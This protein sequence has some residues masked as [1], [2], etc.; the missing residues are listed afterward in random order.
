MHQ[1]KIFSGLCNPDLAKK[2]AKHFGEELGNI[3]INRFLSQELHVKVAED[4]CGKD[5]YVIQSCC[6]SDD[7]LELLIMIDTCRNALA[8]RVTAVIPYLTYMR[9]HTQFQYG[10]PLTAKM[11]PRLLKAAGADHVMTMDL[12]CSSVVDQTHISMENI[13]AEPAMVQWIKQNILEWKDKGII[14]S[15]DDV[16]GERGHQE[17]CPCDPWYLLTL[18]RNTP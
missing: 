6:S 8:W 11:L 3:Q 10:D 5:V 13:S 17:L 7:L 4:I 1:I 12:N 2:I 16:G 9:Q 14:L 18:Q 15:T